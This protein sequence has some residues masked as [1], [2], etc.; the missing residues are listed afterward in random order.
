MAQ[1]IEHA[2]QGKRGTKSRQIKG[3]CQGASCRVLTCLSWIIDRFFHLDEGACASLADQDL[4]FFPC[5]EVLAIGDAQLD[6]AHLLTT[7]RLGDLGKGSDQ[8]RRE[9]GQDGIIAGALLP[10]PELWCH[11]PL[12][13]TLEASTACSVSSHK[14]NKAHEFDSAKS[15]VLSL[16]R[17]ASTLFLVLKHI[18]QCFKRCGGTLSE[19]KCLVL[20]VSQLTDVTLWQCFFLSGENETHSC[21][22]SVSMLL[23]LIWT[24]GEYPGSPPLDELMNQGG[25]WVI[26]QEKYHAVARRKNTKLPLTLHLIFL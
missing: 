7:C 2:P 6:S 12:H 22:L 5:S 14:E 1:S 25:L 24:F 16:C 18:L 15:L 4:L 10:S 8:V 3:T 19:T 26:Q 9:G 11:P 23:C 21:H 17:H 20:T 13:P